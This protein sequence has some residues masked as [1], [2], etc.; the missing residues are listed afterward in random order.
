MNRP[1][2]PLWIVLFLV[3]AG[4]AFRIDVAL[5]PGLWGDEIFSLAMATGHSVEHPAAQADSS[6][7]DF[8]E[9]RQP[10]LPSVFRRYAEHENPPVGVRRVVRA[11]LLS[12]T[13][14]PL[15][16]I[17]L[18]WW[19][20]RFGTDDA[21]LRLFSVWWAV[22][23]LPIVWLL[24]QE[25]GRRKVAWSASLLFSFSPVAIYYSTEGRMY[26]L[27]WFIASAFGWLT[28]HLSSKRNR[29]WV[30]LLWVLLGVAGFLTHY[31]FAFV[32]IACVAWLWFR[33][34]PRRLLRLAAL[35]GVTLL[36]VLPW[37]LELPA[38]LARWRVT[39]DWLAGPLLWPWA[40]IRP[41][42]LAGNFFSGKTELGGLRGVN[43]LVAGLFLAI[44]IRIG[45]Q[46][47]VRRIFS[48]RRL[49][50]WAW[51][52]ATCLGPFAFD[53]L[54]HTTTTD[55]PRYALAG[56]PAALVLAAIGMSQLPGRIHLAFL[57][58]IVAVWLPGAKD[59]RANVQRPVYGQYL[60][61][62]RQLKSWARPDD[63]VLV[64]SIPTGVI[65][66]ARYLRP[67]IRLGS[68]IVPLGVR[69]VPEDLEL[70]LAGCRRVAFVRAHFLHSGNPG[71]QWLRAHA[72]LVRRDTYYRRTAEVLYF[73]P[74][75]GKTFF[76]DASPRA[77]GVAPPR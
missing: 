29:F 18:N 53:V 3:L 65:G 54:R 35:A 57:A 50:L 70:L 62:D 43:F 51:V 2:W 40:V 5:R 64:H 73:E 66:V 7:G 41:L 68:W 38:S 47:S 10:Q 75:D 77:C 11:V 71:E 23:C 37:Y 59:N 72:R 32:W 14:P 6:R 67:D 8:V 56:F 20:R 42:A 15:Y 9:P 36:A 69:R 26:S 25:L 46:G 34:R 61:I 16:Y 28:L 4:V 49:L 31:F 17:L 60:R 48:G 1:P 39:G 13:S 33:G 21:A 44:A 30:P 22:L 74:M 27:L 45:R 58:A 24:G 12:D 55:V 76:P 19:T 63:V 52:A